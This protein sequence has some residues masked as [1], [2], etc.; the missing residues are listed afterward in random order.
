MRVIVIVIIVA[1]LIATAFISKKKERSVEF[2]SNNSP[3]TTSVTVLELFTSE[4]CSSCP[5]ADK[6]LQQLADEN[7]NII[8]LSFHVDYWNRLGWTDPFSSTE[9]TN[10]QQEYASKLDLES[11]YTPQVIVNGEY[12]MVGSDKSAIQTAIGKT[13]KEKN[14][15]TLSI[16]DLVVAGNKM[17]FTVKAE[18][19][20][21]GNELHAALVEKK[22]TTQ[23]KAGENN[24]ATLSHINIVRVFKTVEAHLKN[25]F[26]LS[27]PSDLI[28]SNRSII[29][30]TQNR[31]N[32]RI[33]SAVTVSE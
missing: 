27:I 23:V 12:Q 18:G 30:Y 21:N 13:T 17:N 26:Q 32:F 5:R 24:G 22:A 10:R 3:T 7:K 1:S 20:I 29:L 8:A 31:N 15:I 33:T 28:K 14:N 9:Y 11:V 25:N 4:G 16:N 19:E 2:R 6:L